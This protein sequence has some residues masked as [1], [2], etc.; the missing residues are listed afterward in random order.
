MR[1]PIMPTARTTKDTNKL[2]SGLPR[3]AISLDRI[4]EHERNSTPG[5][6]SRYINEA[7]KYSLP[8]KN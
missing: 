3:E 4:R 6:N 2:N 8:K 5:S 7:S 1:F